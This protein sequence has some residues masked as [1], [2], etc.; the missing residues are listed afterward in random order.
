MRKAAS[1]ITNRMI[2][3][4]IIPENEKEVYQYGLEILLSSLFTMSVILLAA[5][6]TD[7]LMIGIWYLIVSVPLKVTAGGYHA[8]TY[9]R[10]FLI[11]TLEFLAQSLLVKVLTGLSFPAYAW[12]ILYLCSVLYIYHCAPVKNIHHPISE[13]RLMQN[14]RR[15]VCFLGADTLALIILYALHRD[16][17]AEWEIITLFMIAVFILPTQKEKGVRT[18]F[19]I[20]S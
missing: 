13:R 15:A 14:R 8:P 20:R 19:C 2:A 17:L 4:Q 9:T 3:Y 6:L 7:S 18:W 11:S 1:A 10:C 5:S 16:F 12:L